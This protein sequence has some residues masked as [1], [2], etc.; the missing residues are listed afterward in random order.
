MFNLYGFFEDIIYFIVVCVLVGMGCK[1]SIGV[2][3]LGM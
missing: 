1:F 2:L 3:F